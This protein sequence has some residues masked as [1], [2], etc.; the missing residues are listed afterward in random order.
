MWLV[1]SN[2]TYKIQPNVFG[3]QQINFLGSDA[4]IYNNYENGYKIII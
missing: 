1:N 2:N 3:S 4:D